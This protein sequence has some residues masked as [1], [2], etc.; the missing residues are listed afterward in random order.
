M[1]PDRFGEMYA[2]EGDQRMRRAVDE[3]GPK[4]GRSGEEV[5]L[6]VSLYMDVT[7]PQRL[8][9]ANRR[10]GSSPKTPSVGQ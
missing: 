1:D 4:R 3:Q 8:P 9:V 6:R 7:A 10:G 2:R 5:V